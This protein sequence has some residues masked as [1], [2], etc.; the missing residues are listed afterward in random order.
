MPPVWPICKTRPGWPAIAASISGSRLFSRGR[1]RKDK[2][3][4]FNKIPLGSGFPNMKSRLLLF[5]IC[6]VLLFGTGFQSDNPWLGKWQYEECWPSLNKETY[7]CV[8]Y[9]LNIRQE[10]N[11]TIADVDIDGYQTYSRISGRGKIDQNGIKITYSDFRE[12]NILGETYKKGDVLFELQRQGNKII[13]VWNK[14]EPTLDE[15]KKTDIYFEKVT[16]KKPQK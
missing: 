14:L 4:P 1:G 13:T 7:N 3:L 16:A 6:G 12:G 9:I 15:H 10:N 5:V 2:L 11:I 8:T